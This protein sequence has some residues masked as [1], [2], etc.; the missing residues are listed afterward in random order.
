MSD[1]AEEN[2]PEPTEYEIPLT[3]AMLV[4]LG[5]FTATFSQVDFLLNEAIGLITKTPWWAMALMLESAT[6]GPKLNMLRK[7]LSD[8]A[9]KESKRL[10]KDACDRM[11]RLIEKRN[12]V[13]HGMWAR[14]VNPPEP[15][16]NP[17]DRTSRPVCMFWRYKDSPVEASD[18]RKLTNRAAKVSRL[19]GDLNNRLSPLPTMKADKWTAPR[20]LILT[21]KPVNQTEWLQGAELT[22]TGYPTPSHK[23]RG[24]QGKRP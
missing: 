22:H 11:Q 7:C 9:D 24:P 16:K 21:D 23:L 6:T 13:V 4:E 18:L 17:N 20:R 3:D 14:R 1:H 15:G 10:A 5:R 2:T 12:H 8:I 19:L